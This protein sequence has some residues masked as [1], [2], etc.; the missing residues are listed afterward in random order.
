MKIYKE[1]LIQWHLRTTAHDRCCWCG[2]NNIE[3]ISSRE[4]ACRNIVCENKFTLLIPRSEWRPEFDNC[5]RLVWVSKNAGK[6]ELLE[7]DFSLEG[8]FLRSATGRAYISVTTRG[9]KAHNIYASREEP[10]IP[11]NIFGRQAAAKDSVL[12]KVFERA[13][14]RKAW[15]AQQRMS[16]VAV[17]AKHLEAT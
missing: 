17:I 12:W 11:R 8:A 15:F 13:L 10:L 14:P 6:P 7:G 9:G 3:L 5:N 2:L 4:R 1:A 16:D